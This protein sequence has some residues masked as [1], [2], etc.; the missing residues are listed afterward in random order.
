MPRP[1]RLIARDMTQLAELSALHTHYAVAFQELRAEATQVRQLAAAVET[2]TD[3]IGTHERQH[4]L[5][6]LH[7]NDERTAALMTE[8]QQATAALQQ[9]WVAQDTFTL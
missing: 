3:A 2:L 7:H 1:P 9:R 5:T 4:L 6:Q 8:Y